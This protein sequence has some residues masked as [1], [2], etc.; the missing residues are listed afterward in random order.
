MRVKL[1]ETRPNSLNR[2]ERP[3]RV[4]IHGYRDVLDVRGQEAGWHYCWVNDYNVDKFLAGGYEYVTHAVMVGHTRLNEGSQIGSKVSKPVGNGVIGYLLRVP[5]E[6]FQEENR[7]LEAEVD[8]REASM[9]S[10]LNSGKDG[11][12]G[13]VS[14]QSKLS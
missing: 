2:S 5:D 10:D 8:S 14:I 4:P 12:Y 7:A 3:A 9:R 13:K 11:Q 6:I 1:E